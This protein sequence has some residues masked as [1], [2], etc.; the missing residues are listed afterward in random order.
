M[1]GGMAFDGG[2]IILPIGDGLDLTCVTDTISINNAKVRSITKRDI[3]LFIVYL[4]FS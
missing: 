2:S 3:L 4:F 1:I